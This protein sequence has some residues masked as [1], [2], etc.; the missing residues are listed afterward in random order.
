M[1]VCVHVLSYEC[2]SCGSGGGDGGRASG[3]SS[4]GG[5]RY[6]GGDGGGGELGVGYWRWLCYCFLQRELVFS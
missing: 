2:S 1:Y 4:G 6:G 5:A 3:R